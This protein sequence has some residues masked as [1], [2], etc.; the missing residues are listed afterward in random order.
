MRARSFRPQAS[1]ICQLVR[2][3]IVTFDWERMRWTFNIDDLP[4]HTA[5][6]D[7]FLGELC[8]GTDSIER[9]ISAR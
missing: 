3:R 5:S 6:I 4:R 8:A 1:L 9:P 7:K 2:D